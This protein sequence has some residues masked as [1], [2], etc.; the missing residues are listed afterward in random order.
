M[1]RTPIKRSTKPIKKSRSKPRRGQPTK[2]EK[3]AIRNKVYLESGGKCEIH[4]HP[5]CISGRVWPS[6]GDTPWD[7]WHLVHIKAKRVHG[8]DRSNLCGGCPACHLI[9]L[10]NPKSVPP[11][12][13]DTENF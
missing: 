10:H 7:H 9:S 12:S 13:V 2:A 8:W 6:E 4:K 3:T 11:K 1:K 5:S